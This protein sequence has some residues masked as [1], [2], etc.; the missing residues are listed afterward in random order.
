MRSRRVDLPWNRAGKVAVFHW[1]LSM[2]WY[3]RQGSPT[4]KKPL[5]VAYGLARPDHAEGGL[6]NQ[7]ERQQSPT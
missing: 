7:T 6:S 1:R 4:L 3:I 5:R 2:D